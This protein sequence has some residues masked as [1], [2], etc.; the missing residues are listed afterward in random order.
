M[1]FIYDDNNYDDKDNMGNKDNMD[2]MDSSFDSKDNAHVSDVMSMPIIPV[3]VITSAFLFFFT[4]HTHWHSYIRH[5]LLSVHHRTTI[6][7]RATHILMMFFTV[8]R[9]NESENESEN[10]DFH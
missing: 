10:G 5:H 8:V 1:N 3:A 4:A 6:H 2:N 9:G 7:H